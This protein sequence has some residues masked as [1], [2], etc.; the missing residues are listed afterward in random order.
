M[1]AGL[2][3]LGFL[4]WGRRHWLVKA[5][6]LSVIGALVLPVVVVL[7][8]T[9]ALGGAPVPAKATPGGPVPPLAA[10]TMSQ[11]YGC[12]GFAFEPPRGACPHFHFGIDLVAPWGTPVVAALPGEVEVFPAAGPGG[13]YGL[14]V[15]LHHGSGVDTM[16][17]HL[18]DVT[19][20]AGEVVPAGGLLGHEGSSGL[21]TGP[22]LHFEVREA[23]MAVDPVST[24]PGLFG[25]GGSHVERP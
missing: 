17:A 6:T 24:F 5:V 22:H 4:A 23:G 25:P 1:H 19:V 10:W 18:L 21:S 3:R 2:F 7:V 16:Y 15:V 11:P 8:A 14:H 9:A 20:A 12:T 13:G